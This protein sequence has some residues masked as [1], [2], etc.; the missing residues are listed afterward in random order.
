ML[1][2]K[3]KE[4]DEQ[5]I[6]DCP[7]IGGYEQHAEY[8]KQFLTQAIREAQEAVI[9]EEAKKTCVVYPT[10]PPQYPK[11]NSKEY[12]DGW[13]DKRDQIKENIKKYNQ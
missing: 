7:D 5:Y 9:G 11:T 2:D 3:L 1:Q 6:K 4:F 12:C 10:N 13:N 8:F